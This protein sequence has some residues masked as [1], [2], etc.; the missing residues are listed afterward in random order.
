MSSQF[1]KEKTKKN[2]GVILDKVKNEADPRLLNEYRSLFKKEVSLFRRS[3]FTSY[4]LMLYDQGALGQGGR[5][6]KTGFRPAESRDASFRPGRKNENSENGFRGDPA[7]Y[8]LPEEESKWL[9]VGIGRNRRIFPREILGLI[10]TKASVSREDIGAIRILD[11]YSFVQVRDTAADRIIE[12]LNRTNF[13]GKTLVVNYAKT[14]KE[15]AG[16]ESGAA[17]SEAA[18]E[19]GFPPESVPGEYAE[20]DSEQG[21]DHSDK[22][23][24]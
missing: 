9:F 17:D 11:N 20:Y 1:D 21:E 2:I 23:N 5:F 12:T 4:L 16:E 24:I 8:P 10:G 6:R 7:R 3:W 19:A 18:D 15:E 22:E 14:R 13:R